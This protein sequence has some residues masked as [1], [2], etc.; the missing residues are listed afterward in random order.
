MIKTCED[1]KKLDV[2]GY[3]L[4]ISQLADDTILFLKDEAQIPTALNVIARFS[5]ASGLHLNLSKCELMAIHDH[6]SVSLYVIPV[7]ENVKYLGINI[8]KKL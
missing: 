5:E 2:I 3:S 7:K 1:I 6:P 8:S 4:A